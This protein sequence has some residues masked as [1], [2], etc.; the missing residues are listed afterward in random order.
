MSEISFVM[1]QRLL[2]IGA[3]TNPP[4]IKHPHVEGY[5]LANAIEAANE[6]VRNRFGMTRKQPAN[7]VE[8]R[9]VI[10][11]ILAEPSGSRLTYLP[12]LDVLDAAIDGADIRRH[13]RAR[14]GEEV[15]L[16]LR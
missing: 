13:Y 4:N 16:V 8:V 14:S 3:A 9:Q 7:L 10:E 5:T 6:W 15:S 1:Y 11:E 2:Q 12:A